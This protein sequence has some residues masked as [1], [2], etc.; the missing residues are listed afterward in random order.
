MENLDSLYSEEKLRTK[1]A[2]L[3]KIKNNQM[4]DENED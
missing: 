4:L 1:L 3:N 2:E